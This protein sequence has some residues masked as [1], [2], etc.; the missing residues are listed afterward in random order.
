MSGIV[1]HSLYAV[2]GLKAAT[3][4]KLP[5]AAVAARHFDSF[6]A[7]A[8][9]GSDVQTMP[10]AVCV[11]TGREV[12]YG[13]VP[14]EKSPFTGGPVRQFKLATPEGPL[15]PRQ[16]HERFYGRAHLVFGWTKQDAT[17]RVP[18]DHLPEYFAAVLDDAL[19]LFGAGE[20]QL[21]YALGWI[22]H[23]VGDSLI[24]GMQPGVELN[25]LDGRYTPRNRPVQDL[26]SY[27]EIGVQEFHLDWSGMLMDMAATP[28]EPLQLH[29]MRCTRSQGALSQLFPDAWQPGAEPT[30]RA[31]LAENRRWVKQHALDVLDDMKL[32]N[33]DCNAAQRERSGLHYQEMV[34]AADRGGFRDAL[35][36]IGNETAVMFEAVTHRSRALA[37]LPENNGPGWNE[38]ETRWKKSPP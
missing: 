38:I 12:G 8:Y 33:G 4:R 10:E 29:Y 32:V 30:L 26:V 23:V 15:T 3:Q 17:L 36:K 25:L 20:R 5:L 19:P 9:I 14:V 21:A 6:L 22:V 31:V 37:A 7:G 13:T 18:W 11:D 27:H 1:G 16:V 28:V 2:L 34:E 24:K 35:W